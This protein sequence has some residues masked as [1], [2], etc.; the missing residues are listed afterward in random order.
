MTLHGPVLTTERFELWKPAAGDLDDLVRLL[1]GEGMTRFLGPAR[2]TAQAQFERLLRNA[3]SWALYGY[4]IFYVRCR[5][6]R[7]IIGSSGV[8]HSWRGF[9][10]GMDDTPEAGWIVRRDWWGKGVAGEVMR[11]ALPWFDETHGR[12]RIACMIEA[13]NTASER[14]AAALGFVQYDSH[15]AEDG[16][17]TVINLFERMA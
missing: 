7:E 6:E 9:G 13:G 11:S 3:G 14:L 4:G 17:R 10:K 5:G 1:E 16:E 12:H 8:F 2:A 15:E